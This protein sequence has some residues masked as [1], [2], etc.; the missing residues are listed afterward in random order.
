MT[1]SD[2]IQLHTSLQVRHREHWMCPKE[3]HKTSPWF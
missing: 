2:G 3:I 1:Q